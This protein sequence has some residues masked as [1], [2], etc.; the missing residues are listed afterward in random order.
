MQPSSEDPGII[1]GPL[2]PGLPDEISVTCIARLPVSTHPTLSLVSRS[3]RSLLRSHLLFT[4]R[5]H[6]TLSQP[7]LLINIRTVHSIFRWYLLDPSTPRHPIRPLPPSPSPTA[8]GSASA[9]LGPLVYLLG[10]S[11]NG[12]P[13]PTV[14]VLDPRFSRWSSGPR[15]SVGRE[16][17]A[18]GVV[19]GRLHVIGG[20]LPWSPS[21]AES[22]HGSGW[23]PVPSPVEVRE[24][25]MHGSAVVDGRILA[26]A[27]RGG[28]EFDPRNGGRWSAV[29]TV[30]DMGWR[31]KAAVVD[32]VIY[33]YDFLGKIKG[34]DRGADVWRPVEGIDGEL[35][36]FLCGATLANVGGKLF[37]VWERGSGGG[38][39]LEIACAEIEVRTESPS[40][41]L[42][43][44][45]MWSEPSVLVVPK[46]SS[47]VHCLGTEM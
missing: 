19:D 37:V 10:G 44:R 35:P 5:S 9:V 24:K 28:L 17:A 4:V 31:G 30:L 12:I 32:G 33:S 29:S 8:I 7:F 46:G 6:L 40:G 2:I 39:D 21:W 38:K 16:F 36:R 15:L 45:V 42:R 13:Q 25:W 22:L 11:V 43:G 23:A 27:D 18:A 3:W 1:D 41:A 14:S 20:C 47:I 26:V 34:Y